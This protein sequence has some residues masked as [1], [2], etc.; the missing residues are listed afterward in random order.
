MITI[1]KLLSMKRESR[2]RKIVHILES[3]EEAVSVRESINSLYLKEVLH[4]LLDEGLEDERV[5][6]HTK[7]LIRITGE[8]AGISPYLLRRKLNSLKHALLTY[9][10]MEPA[11][12]D[13]RLSSGKLDPEKRTVFPLSLYLEDIRSPFNVGSLFR[14]AES[15]GISEILLSKDCADPEHP[16]SVRSAMGCTYTVSWRYAGLDELPGKIPVFAME[17]GYT[18]IEQFAFP[19]PGIMIVGSEELGVSP[20]A[21]S[22]AENSAGIASIPCCGSKASLNVGVAAGIA[23]NRWLR[24]VTA[25]GLF[26]SQP[27]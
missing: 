13:L 25:E 7:D 19:C 16:R 3:L 10:H 26:R 23:M 27:C 11:E 9:L 21:L 17:T 8:S 4:L 2:L 14:T 6:I 20:E 22:I 18:S 15:F 5:F 12:W 24:S 1:G